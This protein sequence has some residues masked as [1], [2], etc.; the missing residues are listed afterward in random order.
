MNILQVL[1]HSSLKF[2]MKY[3]FIEIE[4]FGVIFWIF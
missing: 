4:D 1:V 2:D 3:N